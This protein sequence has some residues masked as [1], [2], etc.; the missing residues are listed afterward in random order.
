MSLHSSPWAYR[1][2]AQKRQLWRQYHLLDN[3]H[4]LEII[5]AS[6]P[7]QKVAHK[8]PLRKKSLFRL[9][10]E[11]RGFLIYAQPSN[12]QRGLGENVFHDPDLVITLLCIFLVDANGIDPEVLLVSLALEVRQAWQCMAQVVP[13][14]EVLSIND[15]RVRRLVVAPNV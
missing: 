3:P 12:C 14:L 13:Y 4:P 5:I 2:V 15:N 11:P 6:Q 1:V 9:R 10:K 8:I 7:L